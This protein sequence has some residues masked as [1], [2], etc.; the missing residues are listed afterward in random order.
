M[1]ESWERVSKTSQSTEPNHQQWQDQIEKMK[2][3]FKSEVQPTAVSRSSDKNEGSYFDKRENRGDYNRP[4]HDRFNNREGNS[5]RP[6]KNNGDQRERPRSRDREFE[7]RYDKPK[8]DENRRINDFRKDG[9]ERRFDDYRRK[10]EDDFRR[11]DEQGHR[12]YENDYR[13]KEDGDVRRNYGE[14]DNYQNYD[15]FRDEKRRERDEGKSYYQSGSNN[16]YKM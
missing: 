13:R 7:Q 6:W 15:R 5:Q 2:K 10:D 9:N 12:R 4:N 1:T 14:K 8:R 11:N 16:S 3:E